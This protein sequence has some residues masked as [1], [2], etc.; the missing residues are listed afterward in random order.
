MTT[1]D[2]AARRAALTRLA[3]ATKELLPTAK[4]D[5]DA[6]FRI[7]LD[8]LAKFPTHAVVAVCRK[9][10]THAEGGWF[11]KLPVLC[12]EIRAYVRVRAEQ[13][14]PVLQLNGPLLSPERLA[15]FRSDVA[16]EIQRKRMRG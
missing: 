14:K 6:F 16:R 9:L 3:V 11:P 10:E 1:N 13:T 4:E 15:Q 2:S 8:G 5:R 7:Y 12:E